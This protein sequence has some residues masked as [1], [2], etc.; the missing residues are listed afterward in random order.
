MIIK[1]NL[2]PLFE[3]I[4]NHSPSLSLTECRSEGCLNLS[5]ADNGRYVS[6]P[7][8]ILRQWLILSDN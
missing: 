7:Y 3:R 1:F 6:R 2:L 5:F 4:K 8:S